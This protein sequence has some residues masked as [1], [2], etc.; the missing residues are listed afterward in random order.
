MSCR[1]A[2]PFPFPFTMRLLI[3]RDRSLFFCSFFRPL[4]LHGFSGFFLGFFACIL[5]FA[6]GG[7]SLL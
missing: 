4:F 5:A 1:R 7:F 2:M 6:H 3:S